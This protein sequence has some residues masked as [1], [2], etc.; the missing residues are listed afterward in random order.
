MIKFFI[1]VHYL[2]G[3]KI[4]TI[5]DEELL[6]KEFKED[7]FILKISEPYFGGD[8]KELPFVF[9]LIKNI[10]TKTIIHCVGKKITNEFLKENLIDEENLNYIAN[11]PYFMLLITDSEETK[12]K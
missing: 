4:I 12:T 1:K 9:E 11:I 5:C 7:P 10:N 2:E 6:N 3:H 8:L